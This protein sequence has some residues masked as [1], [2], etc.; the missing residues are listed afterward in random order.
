MGCLV[1]IHNDYQKCMTHFWWFMQH[2]WYEATCNA[3]WDVDGE[4]Q[5]GRLEEDTLFRVQEHAKVAVQLT[6]KL[7]HLRCRAT[8]GIPSYS[9]SVPETFP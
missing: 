8:W 7:K 6:Q 9:S 5:D 4:N 2:K 3:V 1:F